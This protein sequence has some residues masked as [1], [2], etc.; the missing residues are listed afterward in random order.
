MEPDAVEAFLAGDHPLAR[1][2]RAA[3]A[4]TFPAIPTIVAI[5]RNVVVL[6]TLQWMTVRRARR[7]LKGEQPSW[8]VDPG[9]TRPFVLELVVNILTPGT[10]LTRRSWPSPE[11]GALVRRTSRGS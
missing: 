8:Q 4:K 3:V 7:L 6:R 1:S 9:T 10:T 2:W 5:A 11:T